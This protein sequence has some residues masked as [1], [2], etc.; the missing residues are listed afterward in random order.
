MT[1]EKKKENN[2]KIIIIVIISVLVIG[3]VLTWGF[4]TNWG[5][6]KKSEPVKYTVPVGI[7]KGSDT[8]EIENP[9]SLGFK[10]GQ[11]IEIG[12]KETRTIVGFGKSGSL[13]L[14][15]PLEYDYSENTII[16]VIDEP[17]KKDFT[18]DKCEIYNEDLTCQKC[19]DLHYLEDNICKVYKTK[20]GENEWLDIRTGSDTSNNTC[21]EYSYSSDKT[22]CNKD[23]KFFTPGT[24]TSDRTCEK[25]TTNQLECNDIIP[26]REI[27]N[28][29]INNK[30]YDGEHNNG[31]K[32]G[33]IK[34]WKLG[35]DIKDLNK[36]FFENLSFNED[37]SGWD[38]SNV[39]NMKDMFSYAPNFNQPL[40]KWD[41][42]NVTDMTYMFSYATKFNQP[43]DKWDVSKVTDMTYMFAGWLQS[44]TPFNQPLNNWD[45]SNVTSMFCMFSF[46]TK[47]NQDISKWDVSN[48]KDMGSMFRDAHNFNQDIST[49]DTSNVTNMNMMFYS[50]KAFNRDISNW[51][52]NISNNKYISR[53][54][55]GATKILNCNKPTKLQNPKCRNVKL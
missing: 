50:A 22:K 48:V 25:C 7:K 31:K 51:N 37:I 11:I 17:K 44:E 36:L 28:Q 29:L 55:G 49:W 41:V 21:Q 32:Y 34:T 6:V 26:N 27:L 2:I 10:I 39:T 16:S 46:A 54:F 5:Q 9:E 14:D 13:I 47:F 8:I 33:P 38:V 18:V 3:G 52:V 45:V 42:S 24:R 30:Q 19:D 23:N 1:K 20:C 4:L 43:L 35:P 40:D 15:K 12:N 53:M